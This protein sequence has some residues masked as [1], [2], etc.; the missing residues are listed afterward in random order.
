MSVFQG[1]GMPPFLEDFTR[2]LL[3]GAFDRTQQPLP[4]GIPK[5]QIVGMQP[6]QTGT[7]AEMAKSFGLDPTTGARTGPAS[8]DPAFKEALD[9]VRAGVQ[10]TTMGIPSLQA[11]QAQFDPSTSNY[12][13]FKDQY[14]QDVTN[15][16][17]KQMDEQA[18]IAQQNLATQAQKAG[19]FGGSR[20]AVQEAELA[21]NLQDIKSRRIFQDLSQNFQQAQAK[22]MN[23]FES[24]AQRR[25][26]AA[27][28]FANVGR[29]QAGIGAQGAGLGAQQFGLEQRGLGALFGIGQQQQAL[30]QA[31]AAEQFRQDQETQQEGLKRLGFFSDILRGVPSSGQA[32]TMQQPT[33]TNPL[34]GALGLG[35]GTFNLFGGD[36]SGAGFNLIN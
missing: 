24:A 32:I 33:F 20:M 17:L 22:A 6:L 23:T 9:T 7:I 5:Q 14:Q 18:A 16:A 31:E 25:L 8:F 1:S 35:L 36:N 34:L 15:E 3:Q 13:Q 10:T 12:Q 30:K 26:K 29:F 4:G 2:R 21:K 19:A 27:P 28:Q 11:A